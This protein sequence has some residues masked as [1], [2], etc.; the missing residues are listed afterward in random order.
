MAPRHRSSTNRDLNKIPNLYRK[1]DK[2]RGKL[3]FQYKDPRNGKFWGLGEDEETAKNRAKQLNAA[4]YSQLAQ[5]SSTTDSIMAD[6]PRLKAMGIPF[7][8]WAE[9]YLK[10]TEDRLKSGEIRTKRYHC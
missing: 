5:T 3:S 6:Q 4:I 8:K 9:E 2:R 7:K 1:F 10:F